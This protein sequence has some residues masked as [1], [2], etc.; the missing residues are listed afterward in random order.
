MSIQGE[1][2]GLQCN[3]LGAYS[4]IVFLFA[5]GDYRVFY[6]KYASCHLWMQETEC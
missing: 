1:N 2:G 3:T 4:I 5:N 6:L